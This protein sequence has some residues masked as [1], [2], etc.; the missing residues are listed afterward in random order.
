MKEPKITYRG[1]PGHFICSDGCVFHLNTLIE[2]KKIKIV[3]STVGLLKLE[4]DSIKYEEIGFNRY[5]E[6]MCF[7]ANKYGKFID[8]DVSKDIT[9]QIKTNWCYD[10]VDMEIEANA[11]HIKIV[12]EICKRLKEGDKFKVIEF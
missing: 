7:H 11:G 6:T 8:A 5:F 9:E 12:N 1:W 10:K 4:H 2:Y 3:V